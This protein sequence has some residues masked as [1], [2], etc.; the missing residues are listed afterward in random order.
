[1]VALAA[2][3]D[4]SRCSEAPPTAP[5]N[6]PDADWLDSVAPGVAPCRGPAPLSDAPAVP[7]PIRML[8]DV[9]RPEGFDDVGGALDVGQCVGAERHHV[10]APR[11]RAS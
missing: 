6:W 3:V 7:N 4:T 11:E 2:L 1:M 10:L 8:V 5:C 9:D